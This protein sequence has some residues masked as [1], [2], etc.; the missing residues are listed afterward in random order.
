MT[1][2][3]IIHSRTNVL[4]N[5]ELLLELFS[6]E[7]MSVLETPKWLSSFQAPINRWPGLSLSKI[8]DIEA[9]KQI[10]ESEISLLQFRSYLF[11]RQCSMLLSTSK[12]WEASIP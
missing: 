4:I 9:R 7:I 2:N 10:R 5:K 11:S 3:A 6:N 12:P 8:L 1:R